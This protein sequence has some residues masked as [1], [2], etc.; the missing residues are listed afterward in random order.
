M[1]SQRLMSN[2]DPSLNKAELL[3]GFISWYSG[4]ETIGKMMAM[5]RNRCRT[6]GVSTLHAFTARSAITATMIEWQNDWATYMPAK[7]LKKV[8]MFIDHGSVAGVPFCGQLMCV[9]CWHHYTEITGW[10]P[11]EICPQ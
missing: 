4:K 6:S 10:L 3:S 7:E 5:R 1:L 2:S 11:E 8:D 9:E